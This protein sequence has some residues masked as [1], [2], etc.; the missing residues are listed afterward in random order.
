MVKISDAQLI[1]QAQE[2]P[3]SPALEM[4]FE[5]YRPVVYR[6]QRHYYLPGHDADDWDQEGRLVLHT[7]VQQFQQSRSRNFGAFYRLNLT[8]RI[9]DLI[10]H[11]QAQKRC[12]ATISLEAHGPYFAETLVDRQAR[13]DDR[14]AARECL[15]R[16]LP[17]LSVTERLVLRGLL[18]GWT[19]ETISTQHRLPLTRVN[20]A[21]HRGRRKLQRVLAE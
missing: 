15:T 6:L 16:V 19:P 7:V 17:G 12:A 10:R 9:I 1:Q 20:A 21:I 14:L 5:R 2:S 3:D 11:S 18:R 4:L 13:L 8:H